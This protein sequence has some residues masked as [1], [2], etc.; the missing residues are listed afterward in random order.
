M[1]Q[2]QYYRHLERGGKYMQVT[3]LPR[4]LVYPSKGGIIRTCVVYKNIYYVPSVLARSI[5]QRIPWRWSCR[6]CPAIG[7][8][9]TWK[10]AYTNADRH[11]RNHHQE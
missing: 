10:A 8:V 6:R 2:H 7:L 9:P 1:N 3:P 4:L 11:A 5:W